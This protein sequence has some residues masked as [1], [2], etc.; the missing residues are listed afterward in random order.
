MEHNTHKF[1]DRYYV[2]E[3]HFSSFEG[4]CNDFGFLDET[5]DSASDDE[6]ITKEENFLN[7][8][9]RHRAKKAEHRHRFPL[10]TSKRDSATARARADKT[11]ARKKCF[12]FRNRR[13]EEKEWD[14]KAANDPTFDAGNHNG[15]I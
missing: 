14:L 2:S 11:N 13:T 8:Q 9:Q 7:T 5:L 10:P 12:V 6:V 3:I 4:F 15:I 1:T